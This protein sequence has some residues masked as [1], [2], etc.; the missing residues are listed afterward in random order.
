MQRLDDI[1]KKRVIDNAVE[2]GMARRKKSGGRMRRLIVAAAVVMIGLPVFGLAFPTVAA[3]IPIIGGLFDRVD[4]HGTDRYTRL[5]EYVNP[6]DEIQYADG[7][8]ITLSESFFDG[9]RIYLTFLVEG[10]R[11]FV[12]EDK[13]TFVPSHIRIV[14]D[15]VEIIQISS[16][17]E[18]Y[19]GMDNYSQIIILSIGTPH[20][21]LADVHTAEVNL[22][23]MELVES[24]VDQE[25]VIASGPWNFRAPIVNV[26]SDHID[27]N[28]TV[29]YEDFEVTVYSVAV[30]SGGMRMWFSYIVPYHYAFESVG[31]EGV[32]AS[33]G[34]RVMDDVDNELLGRGGVSTMI[35]RYRRSNGNRSFVAPAPDATQIIIM[36]VAYITEYSNY[37]LIELPVITIDLP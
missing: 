33:I 36:P 7:F 21:S 25:R 34:F 18:V 19:P 31:F 3:N 26:G 23:I 16:T 29:Y 9:E 4:L 30:S 13:V 35:D 10:D 27:V 12:N 8:S 11:D 28:Q 22:T 1:K 20:H 2:M 32:T 15:D 14:F 5:S 37:G 6:I 17:P 24:N